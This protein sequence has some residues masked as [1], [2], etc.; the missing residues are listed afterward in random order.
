MRAGAY[1]EFLAGGNPSWRTSIT[2]TK[3]PV[4]DVRMGK[5]TLNDYLLFTNIFIMKM[6]PEQVNLE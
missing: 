3:L 1:S 6:T 2:N 5:I 4:A